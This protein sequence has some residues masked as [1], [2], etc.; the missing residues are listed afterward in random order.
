MR[1]SFGRIGVSD[2]QK[3]VDVRAGNAAVTVAGAGGDT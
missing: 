2:V 1:N 3:G